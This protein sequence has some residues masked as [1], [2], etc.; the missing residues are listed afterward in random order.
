MD[1]D[2]K[3]NVKQNSSDAMVTDD[4]DVK[5]PGMEAF[6]EVF[7]RFQLPPDETTVRTLILLPVAFLS[8][9]EI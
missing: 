7:A 4:I 3:S 1:V 6:A 9:L 8:P 2:E 5:A